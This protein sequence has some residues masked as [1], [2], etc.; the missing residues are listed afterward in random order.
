MP[1]EMDKLWGFFS[2]SKMK[3]WVIAHIWLQQPFSLHHLM[4]TNRC[5]HAPQFIH[6]ITNSISFTQIVH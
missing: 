5:C 3:G 1:P 2:L 6:L 4:S